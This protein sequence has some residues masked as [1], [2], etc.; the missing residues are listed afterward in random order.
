MNLIQILPSDAPHSSAIK[1]KISF[2]LLKIKF[3]DP[4][5]KLEI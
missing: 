4:N 1:R 2:T 3:N 5:R